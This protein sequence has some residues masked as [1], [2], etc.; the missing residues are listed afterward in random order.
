MHSN[1]T[2]GIKKSPVLLV[3]LP[4]LGLLS[5]IPFLLGAQSGNWEGSN[6][7]DAQT[8]PTGAVTESSAIL[9][10]DNVAVATAGVLQFLGAATAPGGIL[11]YDAEVRYDGTLINILPS[12]GVRGGDVPF[13]AVPNNVIDNSGDTIDITT[14]DDS[15]GAADTQ[16]PITLAKLVV[17]LIGCSNE[18][19]VLSVEILDVRSVDEPSTPIAGDIVAKTL[20]RGDAR[21]DGTVDVADVLFIA[22]FLVGS[23]DAGEDLP[24]Q[25]TLT[26]PINA[27]SPKQD[28]GGD[29]INIADALF[30]AQLL[31]TLR[32]PCYGLT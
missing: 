25:F 28:S 5:L 17:Q 16:A 29:T 19:A 4:L 12:T 10:T 22:Q 3:I 1:I 8:I 31:A 9:D 21:A 2:R 24:G 20:L 14:F 32:N 18:P 23:R 30:I 15:T 26:H 11:N 7:G 27:A 13:D 6:V